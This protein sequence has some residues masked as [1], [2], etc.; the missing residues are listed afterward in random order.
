MWNVVSIIGDI[1]MT[2]TQFLLSRKELMDLDWTSADILQF[3][4]SLGKDLQ[5]KMASR[6]GSMG[7]RM[8]ILE[9]KGI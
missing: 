8:S 6:E 3:C 2:K 7:G 5:G 1:K 9:K 4:D